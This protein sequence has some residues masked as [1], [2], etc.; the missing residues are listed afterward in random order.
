VYAR[1]GLYTLR[2]VRRVNAGFSVA[3]TGDTF[4]LG[5]RRKEV[6]VASKALICLA[7]A[8]LTVGAC[9]RNS[10]VLRVAVEGEP[11]GVAEVK[12]AIGKD[13]A[14]VDPSTQKEYR[15]LV[16]KPDPS[17]DYKIL[18]EAAETGI[19]YKLRVIDPRTGN[20]VPA[21]GALGQVLDELKR[22]MRTGERR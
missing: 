11:A 16:V 17:I 8:V 22:E 5:D 7:M 13:P 12:A 19:D 14:L 3:A 1:S 2:R 10:G 4:G 15:L 20:E 9:T 18:V 6:E 21:L